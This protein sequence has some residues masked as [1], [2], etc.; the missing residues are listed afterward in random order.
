MEVL[1]IL[2][3]TIPSIVVLAGI[4]FLVAKFL[5]E[6][7][8]R[9]QTLFRQNM[10]KQNQKIAL[11][12][13]LQAYERIAVLLERMHPNSLVTR[14][15]EPQMSVHDFRTA[16]VHA[17]KS[18]FE[19]NQ[20]QQIYVSRDIWVLMIEIKDQIIN[21]VHQLAEQL[22]AEA[23]SIELAKVLLNY[24]FEVE[25]GQFPTEVGLKYLKDEVATLY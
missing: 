9:M 18:E 13:R 1:E 7:R 3:Y 23:S 11:P 19:Y 22:P 5:D 16:L 15:R 4:Y 6:E 24:T 17:I 10:A 8:I 20:S 14:V 12:L 2:K 25:K 21:L